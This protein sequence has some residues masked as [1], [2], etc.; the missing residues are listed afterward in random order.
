MN[1]QLRSLRSV[2]WATTL[3]ALAIGGL[4]AVSATAHAGTDPYRRWA[5]DGKAYSCADAGGGVI[6]VDLSNQNV[7]FDA[8]PAAAQFTINYVKNGVETADGPYTVEKTSGTQ[9]Y[10]AFRADFAAYPLVLDF[11]LDTILDG[12]V[13]YRS[14][15]HIA[16][17][18][19]SG[20]NISP[21]NEVVV[22]LPPTGGSPA[23]LLWAVILVAMGGFTV[24]SARRRRH[25]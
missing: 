21:I 18:G 7:E 17:T 1:D 23:V 4:L 9:N 13:V 16:C 14:T 8:L 19:D 22:P 24:I 15:L 12:V 2:R 11:R 25:A 3:S 20:G 5:D 6:H 10:G